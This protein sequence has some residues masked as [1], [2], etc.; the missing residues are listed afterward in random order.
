MGGSSTSEGRVEVFYQGKWGTICDDS[1]GS[2]DATVVCRQLGF[3]I[4]I[5][6]KSS[7]FFGQGSGQIWIDDVACSGR[8]TR[9]E[10]C[11]HTSWGSHNCRHSE[12]AGVICSGQY[13]CQF[14]LLWI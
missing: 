4:A 8:D 9:V 1:W 2:T 5:E 12:D 14:V 13:H 11:T 7:A 10:E 3:S 6:A